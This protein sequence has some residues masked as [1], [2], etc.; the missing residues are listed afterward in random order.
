MATL[1][2]QALVLQVAGHVHP[3]EHHLEAAHEIPGHQPAEAGVAEGLAQRLADAL[4]PG[5]GRRHGGFLQAEGQRNDHQRQAAEHKQGVLPADAADQRVFHRHHQELAE[6]A[7]RG[8]HAH[9]PAAS[10]PARPGDRS[11]RR[12]P[13]RWCPTGPCPATSPRC[14]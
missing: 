7:R 13:R 4:L 6:G 14:R 8:R 11:P 10:A 3:D 5:G 9:G 2:A 1:G 12:P